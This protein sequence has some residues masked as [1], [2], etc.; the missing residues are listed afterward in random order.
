[1]ALDER[2]IVSSD[3]EQY[4]VNKDTGLPLANGTL[5]FYRD[6]ARNV[7]KEVFQLSGF[8]P[9]YT[10]TSMG[11][12]ITLSA[13][14][15][16]QNSGGDNE[17]IYYFPWDSEGNL[18]LYYIDV[19][20]EDGIQQFTR[21]AWPNIT[22]GN[23]PSKDQSGLQNQI[24]NTTFTN[25]F[26][27]EGKTTTFT[28][29]SANGQVFELA[30]DWD[31]VISGTGTVIVQRIA[32]SGNEK[33]ITSPPYVLDVQVSVG[34]TSCFLRQ[35]FRYNSGLWASTPNSPLFLAGSYVARSESLGTT[36]IQMFYSDSGGASPVLI[37]DGSFQAAYE[38]V[39]GSTAAQIP[40]SND[41]NTGMSGYVDIYLSFITGSHVRV[42][43]IQVVPTAS[44][45]VNLVHYDVDSSNR[46]EVYQGDYYIP[47][48]AAK[49]I[50]SYLVGWE[51]ANNPYQFGASGVIT[52]TPS[53]I[54]DQTIA[55]CGST[56][57]ITWQSINNS[58]GL[59]FIANGLNDSF[60]ILQ[61]LS[62]PEIRT[63][64][65]N[66][67]SVNVL[68][69]Q[70]LVANDK[71]TIRVYLFRGSLVSTIPTL[72]ATIGTLSSDGTF[73]L[74][75]ANWTAIPRSGLDIP[76]A[77]LNK[78]FTNPDVNNGTND[79]GFSGWEI[80]DSTQLITTNKFAIVI[81]FQYPDTNTG[82]VVDSVSVV[83]GDLPCRPAIESLDETLRKCQYYYE[84]S[85]PLTT[86]AGTITPT[87]SQVLGGLPLYESGGRQGLYVKSFTLNYKQ[88]KRAVPG[89][90]LYSHLSSVPQLILAG[91]HEPGAG[92]TVSNFPVSSILAQINKTDSSVIFSAIS[93]VEIIDVA[94]A[95]AHEGFYQYQ[96]VVDARLG[97]V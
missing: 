30:P 4:Y 24:A 27:N 12:Q 26:I 31:F 8:P 32:V 94:V 50:S 60:Y 62:G 46:N 19:R 1:M 51:F 29:S 61:Y 15:T 44:S 73:T 92:S 22:S 81:T 71:A 54:A 83:P 85:Y 5:T 2:Y 80:L 59:E 38:L 66:R 52:T 76:Q 55:A 47:R 84:K 40:L 89:V 70:G 97:I 36:G 16:V 63:I 23:D 43:S 10:Y 68:A 25:V 41:T 79:F 77:K 74:T 53:Y 87:G 18:D 3:I 64:I 20:D 13:V 93:P 14:G 69:Y 9:N 17:V 72:P 65:E 82:I 34:I 42:S 58:P 28:V 11:A 49:R 6:I 90:Y 48:S 75:A 37:V 7:P 95:A 57:T 35:R 21:E 96:Y 39:S 33:V 91:I 56:G 86:V 45:S 78:I 67:L 88:V